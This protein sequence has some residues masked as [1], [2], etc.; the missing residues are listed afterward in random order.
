ML[1]WFGQFVSLTGTG[2]SYFAIALWAWEL[3]GHATA[4]ALVTFFAYLPALALS[5]FAGAVADRWD[6]KRVIIMGDTAAALSTLILLWLN[7][8]GHLEMWH[9]Y[10]TVAF[11]GSLEAFQYPAFRAAITLMVDKEHYG[12]TSALMGLA[13]NTSRIFAPIA[14]AS[15]YTFIKLNGILIIDF[16]TFLVAVTTLLLIHIPSPPA[17]EDGSESQGNLLQEAV[18]GFRY[19]WRRKPL[20]DLQSLFF[21]SNILFAFVLVLMKSLYSCSNWQ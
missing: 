2:M 9:I 5:P 13:S 11:S 14:A 17:S 7:L 20:F 1:V 16:L 15:L 8:I 19:I 4:L 18:Y 10:A 6:R 3:T 12:R 21:F